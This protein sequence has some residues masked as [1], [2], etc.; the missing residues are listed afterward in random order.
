MTKRLDIRKDIALK[1]IVAASGMALAKAY[2]MPETELC[3]VKRTIPDSHAELVRFRNAVLNC[4][5]QIQRIMENLEG[6]IDPQT[7][8]ILDFQLLLLDD[9]EFIGRIE[10]TVSSLNI[11]AE[12]AT[13]ETIDGYVAYLLEM[14]DNDY[15]RERTTDI[16]DL[17]SRLITTLSGVDIDLPEPE[18]PY[19][20]IAR[21]ISPSHV[22]GLDKSKLQGI[23]LEK[24]GITSHCVILSRSLGIPCLIQTSGILDAANFGDMV[25][26]NAI[27]GYVALNPDDSHKNDYQYFVS[28]DE[29][30]RRNLKSYILRKSITSDGV[31]MKTYA[32]IASKSEAAEAAVSGC[33]GVGLFRTE[34]LFITSRNKPPSE[35][36]QYEEYSEAAKALNGMPL[37]IRTLDIGGDKQVGYMSIE[38]EGNPFLGY[39]AIRYCLDHPEIFKPQIS[40]I[41]RAGAVGNIKM[42][43]PMIST[44]AELT[45]AKEMVEQVKAELSEKGLTF[46]ANLKIGI[47]VE[48]PAAAIDAGVFAREVDFFSIGTNDLSQYMFAADRLNPKVSNLNSY[49]Q[50][51]LLRT[52]NHIATAALEEDVELDI[53]GQAAEDER[54]IP[55]WLA[56]D[57]DNLSVSIPSITSIRRIIC[58]LD[59]MKCDKLLDM[60]LR[61]DTATEVERVLTGFLERGSYNDSQGF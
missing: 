43:F 10:S 57:I 40:A 7:I 36:V 49:Y 14:T 54:L 53:C 16:L 44:M 47:M 9:T 38:R 59:K 25:L 24:G 35:E 12:Y 41:L 3:I 30:N 58:N 50:P 8:E 13:K 37:V 28:V 45:G 31:E 51:T 2:I 26:L 39:R 33:E 18:W 27:A 4:R 55:V 1:G 5:L 56:M 20:A 48:T 52:I 15:L 22:F 19:V 61:L 32:N 17:S 23:I 21:D 6:V 42:M 46:D 34:G 29:E 11:N 60:I